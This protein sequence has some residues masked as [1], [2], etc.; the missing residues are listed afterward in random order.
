M[1]QQRQPLL[2]LFA[3]F[4]VRQFQ[5]VSLPAKLLLVHPTG[6]PSIQHIQMLP[7]LA[8][9]HPNLEETK[10]HAEVI[11]KYKA[12][13]CNSLSMRFFFCIASWPNRAARPK[14]EN[15]IIFPNRGMVC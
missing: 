6:V 14:S 8:H 11:R 13:V 1:S 4:V 2:S 15:P 12:L 7:L 10:I 9:D 5:R 3:S